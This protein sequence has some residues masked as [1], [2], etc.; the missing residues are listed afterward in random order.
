[1][2]SLY[3]FRKLHNEKFQREVLD[4]WSHI[5]KQNAFIEGEF[6]FAFERNFAKRQKAEF[7]CL[8]AN[9]T[10]ALELA[11]LALDVKPG[12]NVAVPQITFHATAEAV[13]NVGARPV[14]IDCHWQTGLM[15][16]DSL[17]RMCEKHPLKAVIPTH[18][19]GL[20]APMEEIE[21]ICKKQNILIIEDAAQAQGGY[22]SNG[23]PIGSRNNLATFSFY[24]TKNLGALGDAG[25][26]LGQDKKL[27]DIITGIR[28]HGRGTCGKRG[29]RNSRCDHLQAAVLDYKLE[30][31]DRYN[32]IRKEMADR[33]HQIFYHT[34]VQIVPDQYLALS[35]WHLYPV[36]FPSVEKRKIVQSNLKELHIDTA[37][38][39]EKVLS[40]Y[41]F[42][43]R[44]PAES[45]NARRL[46]GHVLCLPFHPFLSEQD[47][48][49][50]AQAVLR[51]F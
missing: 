39:Y 31:A 37:P 26:I 30:S 25:A 23:A 10:D 15:D 28:N 9:G 48:Q 22:Y 18:I 14:L 35:S 40:E 41:P 24:P 13:L 11:M 45:E 49:T 19:Y 38:F 16:P 1:M 2:I 17:Q 32:Q 29:G 6:N 33:Y 20:P 47:I 51:H 44:F 3:D 36:R 7:C 34:P 46:S 50:V 43:S 4:R 21:N 42:L 27:V 8:V 5:L 12:D